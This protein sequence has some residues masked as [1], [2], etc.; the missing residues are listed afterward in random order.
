MLEGAAGGCLFGQPI[1]H[2]T[3]F[4]GPFLLHTFRLVVPAART[5]ICKAVHD[6]QAARRSRVTMQ[7]TFA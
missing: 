7:T 4:S 1:L 6:N 3:V 5:V 2:M